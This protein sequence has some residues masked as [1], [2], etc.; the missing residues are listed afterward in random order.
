MNQKETIKKAATTLKNIQKDFVKYEI[1]HV[2]LFI[3]KEK[4]SFHSYC[5]VGGDY[6]F[7]IFSEFILQVAR[8]QNLKPEDILHNLII[9]TLDD[10]DKQSK[11]INFLNTFDEC[12]RGSL[13][14]ETDE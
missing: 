14:V 2:M 12:G 4:D 3:D 1:P 9:E 10:S 6:L 5:G 13:V 11:L 8:M 7:V